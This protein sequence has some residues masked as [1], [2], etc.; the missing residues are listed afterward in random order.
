MVNNSE[1][2]M[3]PLTRERSIITRYLIDCARKYGDLDCM[4]YLKRG[5]YVGITWKE[6]FQVTRLFALGLQALGIEPQDRV[7]LMSHTRYEW[8]LVD[9]GIMF[10]GA[11]TV[12]IYPSLTAA[13]VEY[14]LNDSNCAVVFVDNPRN[15]RKV[16][17]VRENCP[18]LKHVFIIEPMGSERPAEVLGLDDLIQK[19]KPLDVD[20]SKL[21]PVDLKVARPD[22]H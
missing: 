3:Q 15:L 18:N 17:S 10:A 13:Q 19:G 7:A 5:D 8:R 1:V 9:Y 12:T 14:I 11:T 2:K 21:K 22:P 16:Q 4:R 20:T 6:V